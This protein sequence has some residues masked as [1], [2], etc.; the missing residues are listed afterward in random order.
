MK[1]LYIWWVVSMWT[2][3]WTM[4]TLN[5]HELLEICPNFCNLGKR[6]KMVNWDLKV[7]YYDLRMLMKHIGG[8]GNGNYKKLP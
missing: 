5:F 1:I 6:G 3:F 2:Q 4:N 8:L 7:L